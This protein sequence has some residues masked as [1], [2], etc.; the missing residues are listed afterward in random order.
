MK[1]RLILWKICIWHNI[2]TLSVSTI[3]F[4]IFSTWFSLHL[5]Q[6]GQVI[7]IS[8]L[9]SLQIGVY[10]VTFSGSLCSKCSQSALLIRPKEEVYSSVEYTILQMNS[11]RFCVR[12]RLWCKF[13][14]NK[15]ILQRWS[16]CRAFIQQTLAIA[17]HRFLKNS[18][19]GNTYQGLKRSNVFLWDADWETKQYEHIAR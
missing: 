17:E 5:T 15:N 18:A 9:V 4:L 12:H 19:V 3:L 14:S 8:T 16:Y 2:K 13:I 10:Y 1:K 7:H 6:Y 11:S